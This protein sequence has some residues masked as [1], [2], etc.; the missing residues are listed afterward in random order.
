[1]IEV[2]KK[3]LLSKEQKKR[4]IEGAEFVGEKVFTDVYY[5]TADFAMT[6][7]DKWLRER[8]G[9]YELKISFNKDAAH[10]VG[11]LYEEVED[12]NK[13]REILG[14][15]GEEGME[16]DLENCGYLKFCTCKTTRRKYRKEGF[17]IDIDFVEYGDGFE[18]GLAEIELM[19]QDEAEMSNALGKIISFAESNG[20]ETGYVRGKV[21]VYLREKKPEHFWALVKAGVARA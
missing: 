20:L 1:M 10:R 5:D 13:I 17:G 3:F 14:I 2:E 4:L 21:L 7:N 11:D 6:T 9:K 16:K 12:E 19:V 8:S 15:T 18:Y